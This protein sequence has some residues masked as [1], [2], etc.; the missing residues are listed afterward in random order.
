VGKTPPAGTYHAALRAL[1]LSRLARPADRTAIAA[2]AKFLVDH[3]LGNGQWSYAT[4][5]PATAATI[6]DNSNTAYAV[7]GLAA[8]RRA[9][10]DVPDAVFEKAAAWWRSSVNADGGWG[11]RTDRETASYA[12]MTESG[13]SSLLLCR[14]A[15]GTKAAD[16]AL[17]RAV[18]WVAAHFAVVENARS[19]YQQGRVLYHL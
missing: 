19:A 3:Q 8:C 14:T 4:P 12:S 13:A 9:G 7:L 10:M 17:D 11:Y 2:C 16:P 5:G 18:A 15:L 6:G 1:A